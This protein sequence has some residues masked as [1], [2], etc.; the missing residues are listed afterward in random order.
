M[1]SDVLKNHAVTFVGASVGSRLPRSRGRIVCGIVLTVFLAG[2]SSAPTVSRRDVGEEIDLSGYWNDTDSRLVS[3][4]MVTD[5]LS[6]PW[7]S[8]ASARFGRE[9]RVIVGSV[10]NRS[11]E[12]LNT[13]TFVKDLERALVNSGTIDVVA[14]SD[15]R[16]E[17]RDERKDQQQN[18]SIESAKSMGQESG[19]DFMLQGQINSILDA[20]GG[21]QVR[22]YQVELEIVDLESNRKVWIG[23]KKLKKTVTKP[24]VRW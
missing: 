12:H 10:K 20:A 8:K 6:R 11:S 24:G 4:E 7:S 5:C 19:A 13:Q 14:S 15:E 2:C 16:S 23:Q 21:Q 3:E 17:L 22:F 18:S 9:P 1:T